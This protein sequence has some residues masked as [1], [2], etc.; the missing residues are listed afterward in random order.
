MQKQKKKQKQKEK[1]RKKKKEEDHD[2]SIP[3]W[4]DPICFLRS[5]MTPFVR[6]A[7]KPWVTWVS[8]IRVSLIC[9]FLNL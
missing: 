2:Y 4:L 8:A 3:F 6:V 1:Q 9:S 5:G 7:I